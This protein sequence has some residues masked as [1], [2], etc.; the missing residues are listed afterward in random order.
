MMFEFLRA[1]CFGIGCLCLLSGVVCIAN[2][3][4]LIGSINLGLAV[5]VILTVVKTAPDKADE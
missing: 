2:G 4:Y 1:F 3:E 5:A